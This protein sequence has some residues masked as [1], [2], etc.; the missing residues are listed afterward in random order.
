MSGITTL[1]IPLVVVAVLVL[2]ARVTF[3]QD[4]EDEGD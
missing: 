3:V 4:K 1:A 2:I